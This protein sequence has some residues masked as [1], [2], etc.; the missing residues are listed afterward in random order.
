MRLG[1]TT[2]RGLRR[3][4]R[5]V[6]L[7]LLVCTPSVCHLSG[8]DGGSSGFDVKSAQRRE[9]A[10]IDR[11]VDPLQCAELD[12]TLICGAARPGFEPT[13]PTLA[14]P[15][16]LLPS[17]GD[18]LP[19]VGNATEGCEVI[20]H[21]EGG[22]LPGSSG[23]IEAGSTVV[24]LAG[25]SEPPTGWVVGEADAY[26]EDGEA[27]AA[28]VVQLA[29]DGPVALAAGT[30][31]RVA[32]VVYPPGMNVPGAPTVIDLLSELGADIAVVV[33]DLSLQFVSN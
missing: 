7:G 16:S 17:T 22:T 1:G 9:Q 6:V 11:V 4:A 21:L 23:M 3:R 2:G 15:V 12:S 32:V 29:P 30:R 33:T 8:C 25:P 13:V 19:C 5:L 10:V 24:V 20:V 28:L 26:A 18:G 27:R 14:L 31:A